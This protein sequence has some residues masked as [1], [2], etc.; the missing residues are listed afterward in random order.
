MSN[1]QRRRIEN[2]CALLEQANQNSC[3]L[4]ML[5]DDQ[6]LWHVKSQS[7]QLSFLDS[8]PSV[9]LKQLLEKSTKLPLREKRILAVVLANSLLQLCESPWFSK[10]WSKKDISFF[11]KSANQVDFKRPYLSTHFQDPQHSAD[12]EAMLR[13]HPN[14]SILALGI[15]L[16]EIQL[17]KPIESQR[18]SEDL[19]DGER[20]N[21]NTDLTTALRL[22]EDSVDDIYEGYRTAIQA[23]L[24]CNF[25]TPDQALDLDNAEFRQAVYDNIVSPLEQELYHGFKMTVKDLE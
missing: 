5:V 23:C 18:S 13:I 22:L 8:E 1:L 20:V 19:I 6:K 25:V 24:N 11:H 21:V 4:R 17:G 15:L 2:I 16:L 12:P 10:E 14:Q 7:K 9:S 3:C